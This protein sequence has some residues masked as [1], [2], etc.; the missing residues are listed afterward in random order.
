MANEVAKPENK[1]E[2]N[3]RRAAE[4]VNDNEALQNVEV[5][6]ERNKKAINVAFTALIVI[7]GGF[8]AYKYMYMGPRETKAANKAYFAQQYYMADSVEKA[9]NGDGQHYGFLKVI[10]EFGGTKTAN[11]AH[12]YAGSS[13]LKMGDAKKAIQQLEDFDGKGTLVATAAYGQ[14]GDA[15]M[16]SGNTDKGISNYKKATDN[17]KDV[18]QT[19]MYLFKLGNAYEGAKKTDDAKKAYQRIRDEFPTSMQARDIERYLARLG[20]I[21]Q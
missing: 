6:Y 1:P 12:Y 3:V 8:L 16:Q 18:V 15:Y 2:A 4:E 11:L 7:V 20:D 9:L 5:F 21:E 14:L 13:Y 17:D 19:P 10:R